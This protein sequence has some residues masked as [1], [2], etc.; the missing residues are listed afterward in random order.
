MSVMLKDDNA[1]IDF[2]EDWSTWLASGETIATSSWSVSPSSLTIDSSTNSTTAA[3]AWVSGGT[4]GT[5]YRLT[6]RIVTS[7]A[8][9]DER[10][11]VV[12]VEKR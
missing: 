6:N 11:V 9:T 7:A 3:T 2:S 4:V 5:V 1:V 12:R 8:R 10:T